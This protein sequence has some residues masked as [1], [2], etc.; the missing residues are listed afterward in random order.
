MDIFGSDQYKLCKKSCIAAE[1]KLKESEPSFFEKITKMFSP[2]APSVPSTQIGGGKRARKNCKSQRGGD[3]MP[4][5]PQFG[6]NAEPY[7]AK[8]GKRNR[9]KRRKGRKGTRKQRK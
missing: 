8:G 3:F 9:T 5:Q 2:S 1:E 7:N 6:A 4:N